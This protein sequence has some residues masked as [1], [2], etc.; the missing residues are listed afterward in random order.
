MAR[1]CPSE[2]SSVWRHAWSSAPVL[3][4]FTSSDAF[5]EAFVADDH[6]IRC[7]DQV[8][9]VEFHPCA[10]VPI[11]PQDLEP[12]ASNAYRAWWACIDHGGID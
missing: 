2:I 6:L 1:K 11:I 10:L 8:G 9:I 5:G 7:A 12:T 3:R 4:D